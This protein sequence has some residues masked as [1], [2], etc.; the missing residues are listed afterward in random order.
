[1]M[2]GRKSN[3]KNGWKKIDRREFYIGKNV[4]RKMRRN[5][6]GRSEGMNDARMDLK[7]EEFMNDGRPNES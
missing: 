3:K 7:S 5:K 1:M 2:V 4:G 6:T